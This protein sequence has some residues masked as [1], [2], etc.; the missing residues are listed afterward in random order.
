MRKRTLK[1]QATSYWASFFDEARDEA[2]VIFVGTLDEKKWE[3]FSVSS[4][5]KVFIKAPYL[6]KKRPGTLAVL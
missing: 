6:H 1:L 3:S 5:K 4:R 2:F